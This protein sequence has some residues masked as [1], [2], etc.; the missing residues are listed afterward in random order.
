MSKTI[1]I[2]GGGQLGRMLCEP[3][4]GLGYKVLVIDPTPDCPAKQVGAEQILAGYRDAKAIKELAERSDYLTIEFEHINAEALQAVESTVPVNPAPD[5]ISLIQNKYEQKLFLKEKGFAV[6]DFIEINSSAQAEDTF[7]E[8]GG[9]IV[10][11]KTDSFDGRGNALIREVS[12]LKKELARFEGKEIFAEKIINFRKELAV[13]IAKDMAG[14]TLA[15]PVVETVHAR[16]I[17]IEVYA[18]ADVDETAAKKARQTA[19]EAVSKLKGAGVYGVEMFLAEDGEIL[20]NEIAPRVHNSGHYTM[21]MFAPDQFTQHILAIAGEKLKQP[22]PK[23]EYCCMINILGERDGPVELKGVEEA[24]KIPGVSVYIYG[25]KPTKI[26]RKMGHINAV[27]GTMKEA[28]DNAR[29]AR[30]LI[31]I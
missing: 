7:N 29:K 30:K 19:K 12:R 2:V 20:I 17:C 28:K 4:I 22:E 21:D 10:K 11:S 9:M 13:M 15:Y 31:S 24:Q 16:N 5:T 18:P 3:A 14:N 1:G 6:A 8:W 27:A 23:A 26:D 25:K